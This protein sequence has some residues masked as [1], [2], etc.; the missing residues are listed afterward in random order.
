MSIDKNYF[1]KMTDEEAYRIL[2][3]GFCEPERLPSEPI[4]QVYSW[5]TNPVRAEFYYWCLLHGYE[6]L[7]PPEYMKRASKV[8]DK[9]KA[10]SEKANADS[11]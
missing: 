4:P 8:I 7:V 5:V 1:Y 10:E 3:Y 6:E 9:Y 11:N 2:R